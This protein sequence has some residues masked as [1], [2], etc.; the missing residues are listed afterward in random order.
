MKKVIETVMNWLCQGRELSQ[1]SADFTW[2]LR[3]LL[4]VKSSEEMEDVLDVSTENLERIKE[5]AKRIETDELIRYIR[6]FSDLS[7]QLKYATQKRVLTEVTFIRLCRPQ[8]EVKTDTILSRIRALE[9]EVKKK[10][11][12]LPEGQRTVYVQNTEKEEIH[13]KPKAAKGTE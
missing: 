4:L 12:A 11:A 2:Y 1:L 6:I 8:M 10:L 9:D 5:E 3:N 7:N 13:P